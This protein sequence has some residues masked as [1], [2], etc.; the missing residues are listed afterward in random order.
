[1]I[2][3]YVT[4]GEKERDKAQFPREP[5]TLGD[6]LHPNNQMNES[7]CSNQTDQWK[8]ERLALSVSNYN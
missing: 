8:Y 1:M 6:T 2:Q 4:G 3:V 7:Q 5:R